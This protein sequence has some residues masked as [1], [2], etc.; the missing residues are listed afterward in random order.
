[1]ESVRDFKHDIKLLLNLPQFERK[2]N[3]KAIF[4]MK[5]ILKAENSTK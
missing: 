5:L 2:K 1:M 4:E 3:H